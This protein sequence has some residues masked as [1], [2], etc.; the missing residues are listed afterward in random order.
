MSH[1]ETEPGS[2]FSSAWPPGVS[3]KYAN[4]RAAFGCFA[5]FVIPI[6]AS[7][8]VVTGGVSMPIGAPCA[9]SGA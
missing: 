6:V 1:G 3:R 2:A 5:S 8:P 7:G 9:A 4:S